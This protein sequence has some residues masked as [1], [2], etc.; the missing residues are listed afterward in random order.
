MYAAQVICLAVVGVVRA[1]VLN[2]VLLLRSSAALGIRWPLHVF[3][4][5]MSSIYRQQSVITASLV[6]CSAWTKLHAYF[7]LLQWSWEVKNFQKHLKYWIAFLILFTARSV[8]VCRR[9]TRLNWTSEMASLGLSQWQC[10]QF[11]RCLGLTSHILPP[12]DT[13]HRLVILLQVTHRLAIHQQGTRQPATHQQ[14]THQP[15]TPNDRCLEIE[16]NPRTWLIIYEEFVCEEPAYVLYTVDL[17]MAS[18]H[19]GELI[20]VEFTSAE[21]KL[22]ACFVFW[23]GVS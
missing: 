11:S 12:L 9:N 16:V 23:F 14:G 5:R 1:A 17:S 4:Y 21:L 8:R 6:S 20:F 3:C 10:L 2:F 22:N 13:H 15:A 18:V 7:P 19:R